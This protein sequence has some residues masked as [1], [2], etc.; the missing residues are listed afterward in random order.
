LNRKVESTELHDNEGCEVLEF[1]NDSKNNRKITQQIL[2]R[3]QLYTSN[4]K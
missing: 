2:D 3:I 4:K 1:C